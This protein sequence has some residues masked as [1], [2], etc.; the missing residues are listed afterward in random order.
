[1]DKVFYLQ[2]HLCLSL[3]ACSRAILGMYRPQLEKMGITYPQH[4][5]LWEKDEIAVKDLGLA[6]DLDSGTLTP[7]LKWREMNHLIIRER[8]KEDERIVNVRLTDTDSALR[9]KTAP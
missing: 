7:L 9:E 5:V 8:S 4:L 3:Y 2:D 1:M 6:L